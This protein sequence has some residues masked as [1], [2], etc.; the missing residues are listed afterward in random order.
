MYTLLSSTK[1]SDLAFYE[2]SPDDGKSE[3]LLYI[4]LVYGLWMLGRNKEYYFLDIVL[5]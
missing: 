5:A 3:L 4:Q 1:P 2:L